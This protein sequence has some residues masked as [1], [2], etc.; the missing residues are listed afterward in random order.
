M[1]TSILL[2]VFLGV[3]ERA[4][5]N[6]QSLTDSP[7]LDV[8]CYILVVSVGLSILF[9][10]N[11]SSGGLDIV[12]KILN[13]YLHIDLGKAMSLPQVA[14]PASSSATFRIMVMDD[15]GRGIKLARTMAAPEMLLTAAWLGTR[16]K[17]TA[18]DMMAMAAV[19]MAASRT[20]SRQD[21]RAVLIFSMVVYQT[22]PVIRQFI[23]YSQ[24]IVGALHGGR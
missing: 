11:A 24:R 5:P 6:Y 2:P 21:G 1:Y 8:I 10:R 4:F 18:A 16:K 7:E 19:R 15:M 23:Q 9:N 17:N 12:A 14:K 22:T 3:L 20:S 13:K